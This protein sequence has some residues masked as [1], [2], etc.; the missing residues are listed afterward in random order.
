M[1]VG[2][3]ISFAIQAALTLWLLDRRVGGLDLRRIAGP[4]LKMCIATGLMW[5]ACKLVQRAP[6]YPHGASR[7]TWL[8]QLIVLMVVGAGVYLG[9]CAAMGVD[10]MRQLFPRKNRI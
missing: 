10:T 2:T 8:V 5:G 1:A 6:G 9:A 7:A 3:L 4:I